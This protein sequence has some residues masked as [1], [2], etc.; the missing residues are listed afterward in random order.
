MRSKKVKY[1]NGLYIQRLS[2][3]IIKTFYYA[4]LLVIYLN[5]AKVTVGRHTGKGCIFIGKYYL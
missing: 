4:S 3:K 2:H 5:V 1:T